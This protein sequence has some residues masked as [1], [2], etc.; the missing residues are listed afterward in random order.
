[1]KDV[2]IAKSGY[3]PSEKVINKVQDF[4]EDEELFRYCSLPE[5]QD[6]AF[7]SFYA[8]G[9]SAC[10]PLKSLLFILPSTFVLWPLEP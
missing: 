7:F 8:S 10:S 9:P 6:L 4:Q 1:M 3:A 5:V 2:S